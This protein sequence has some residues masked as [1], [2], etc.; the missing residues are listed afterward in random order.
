ME[1]D[2]GGIAL[3]FTDTAGDA[4]FRKAVI[5]YRWTPGPVC[6]GCESSGFARLCAR[7]AECAGATAEIDFW[8]SAAAVH[9]NVLGAGRDAFLTA[10]A[11]IK[12]FSGRQRAGRAR[13]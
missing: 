7:I 12:E 13:T 11:H 3:V 8:I 2:R 10:R 9:D 1:A 5:G 4:G 6:F